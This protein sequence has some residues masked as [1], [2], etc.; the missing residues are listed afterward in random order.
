MTAS[1]VLGRYL[2][3]LALRRRLKIEKNNLKG[4]EGDA[5]EGEAKNWAIAME[6]KA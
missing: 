6:M 2:A 3:D 5:R 1:L 4:R